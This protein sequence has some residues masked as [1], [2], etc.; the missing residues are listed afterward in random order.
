VATGALARRETAI[1]AA[2]ALAA[3]SAATVRTAFVLLERLR[4]KCLGMVE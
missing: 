1:R 4:M 2:T 3:A